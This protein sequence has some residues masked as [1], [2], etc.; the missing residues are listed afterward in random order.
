MIITLLWFPLMC[1][2]LYRVQI[3]VD[4]IDGVCCVA[5]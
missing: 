3:I 4:C 1:Y 2:I 5:R